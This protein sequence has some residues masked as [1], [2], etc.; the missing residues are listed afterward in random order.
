MFLDSSIPPLT[1]KGN[2]GIIY[3]SQKQGGVAQSVEQETHKLC[4]TGSIPVAATNCKF[5]LQ[6]HRYAWTCNFIFGS[7]QILSAS[8]HCI[9]FI[10]RYL[11]QFFSATIEKAIQK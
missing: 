9:S 4:V 5:A 6:V 10:L 8:V 11:T 1:G 2:F 7:Y 3:L